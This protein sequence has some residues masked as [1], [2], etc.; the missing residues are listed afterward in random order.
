MSFSD[1]DGLVDL[2]RFFHSHRRHSDIME[3][4]SLLHDI[5]HRNV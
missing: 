3:T 2:A 1:D 4:S 5:D